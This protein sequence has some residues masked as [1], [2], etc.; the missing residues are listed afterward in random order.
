MM[1]SSHHYKCLQKVELGLK[2]GNWEEVYLKIFREEG[3]EPN[4][5]E[6]VSPGRLGE[7]VL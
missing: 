4:T 3:C 7:A 1:C 6:W 2:E 5:N